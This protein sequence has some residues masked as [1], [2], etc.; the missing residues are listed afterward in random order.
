MGNLNI[1]I[2]AGGESSRFWPLKQKNSYPFLGKTNIDILIDR[3]DKIPNKKIVLVINKTIKINNKKTVQIVQKGVG[4][5]GGVATALSNIDL[6]EEILILNANDFYDES[7]INDFIKIRNS[8][9]NNEEAMIVGYKTETYFPG[10]YLILR[11]K[12]ITGIIEKPGENNTPSDYVNIVFHYFPKGQDLLNA[13]EKSE[14][15]RDD[16]YETALDLM[17]KSGMKFN[18]LEYKNQWETIKYPWH[19]LD[20]MN[21][22]LDGLR[23]QDISPLAQVSPN[24]HIKGNVIIEEGVKVFDG[25]IV[26]GPCFIGKNTIVA[27]NALVRQSIIGENCVIGFATEVARSYFKDNVWLHKNYVG[28]SIFESNVSLGSNTVTGN[29][30]LDEQ[31]ILKEVRGIKTD[32]RRNKLGS[33]VG[34]DVRIGINVNLMPGVSIGQNSFIGPNI[35]IEKDINEKQFVKLVQELQIKENDFDIKNTSREEIKSKLK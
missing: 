32:T 35:N 33:I 19:I 16:V 22:F 26:N 31:N 24:S 25:A 27:N 10:G 29:L 18:I 20:V 6:N 1:I 5:A 28:D 14:S 17:M 7:L 15:E 23:G 11:D 4:M 2:L 3:F 30:R 34:S 9:N 8:L 21:F 12:Y 13:L